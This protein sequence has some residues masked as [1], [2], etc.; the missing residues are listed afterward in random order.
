MILTWAQQQAIKPLSNN[1]Q[2]K[3]EQIKKE[4]EEFELS[5]LLGS[6]FYYEIVENYDALVANKWKDLVEGSVYVDSCGDSKKHMGLQY[7]LAYLV[8]AQ[9]VTESYITDTFTGMVQKVRQDSEPISQGQMKNMR[10]HYREIAFNY[11]DATKDYLCVN[12]SDFENWNRRNE[13]K[14]NTFK[15]FGIKKI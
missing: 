15:I 1:N 6:V 9:Y 8:T 4:V 14:K 10:N 2:N 11:F 12:S 7:V 5:N 3:F 13:K